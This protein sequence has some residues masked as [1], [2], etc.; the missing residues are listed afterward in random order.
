MMKYLYYLSLALFCIACSPKAPT[1]EQLEDLCRNAA[2]AINNLK[3]G[4]KGKAF[5]EVV[6][7][8]AQNYDI[9]KISPSQVELLFDAGGVSLDSYLREWLAPILE[10]QS[11]QSGEAGALASYYRWKYV[12]TTRFEEM[13]AKEAELYKLMLTNASIGGVLSF[14]WEDSGMDPER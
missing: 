5:Q 9:Q 7:K 13:A 14:I 12:L 11:K 1:D 2:F 4:D 3:E 6:T 8:N 10:T